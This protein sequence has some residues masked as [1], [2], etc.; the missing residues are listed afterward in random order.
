M[1]IKRQICRLLFVHVIISSGS[2]CLAQSLPV[3]SDVAAKMVL[4]D[5]YWING[6]NT[7]ALIGNQ[8]W[9]RAAY[10]VGNMA[11]YYTNN[12]QKYLTYARSWANKW[13]W[14]LV[15]GNTNR[16]ADAQCC[17][18]TYIEL[19]NIDTTGSNLTNITTNIDYMV[20]STK[21]DDWW[22]C[23]ALFMAMPVFTK[24][25]SLYNNSSYFNKLYDLY[26]DCKTR[27]KLY[28]TTA[29]LWY[30]DGNFV[31]PNHPTPNGKKCFW[32][33]GNG[34]AF[35]AH[36]RT[37]QLLPT[38]DPHYNEYL[39]TFKKMASALKD[40]QRSDG[41]WNVSLY[42]PQ[43][44]PGPET[45][46]TSFFTYGLAWGINNGFLD[47][48]TYETV[49]AKAWNGL[50]SIAV[51][52]DG[53]LGYVQGVGSA[54]SSS[55]LVTYN[56]TA[57]FGVGAFLLAGS[58]VYKLA[59][60]T[61]VAQTSETPTDYTLNQNYPNPFNPSTVISYHLPAVSQVQIKV[62]DLLGREVVTLVNEIQ[63]PGI[64]EAIF[65]AQNLSLTSGI[66]F[67]TM[68]TGKFVQT[69]KMILIK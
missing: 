1:C 59:G 41:F 17:G 14:T 27:R 66:Y 50:T 8:D 42:D 45:S 57:D 6:H 62:F 53:F 40:V 20:N 33:R 38:S 69:K 51:H 29:H 67:Y 54:P 4:V 48:V 36:A 46:G 35:A 19:Y 28:D 30:R 39:A 49:V 11:M 31:Y 26:S 9:A 65:N 10:F 24:I 15:G 47:K 18:Q 52:S 3:K 61:G 44:F 16:L 25:G 43:D 63:Q 12:D 23:D 21:K 7:D 68:N 64:H 34:W 37:L 22:W 32:S 58:E 56:H 5:D 55:Q 13:K 60:T 2:F